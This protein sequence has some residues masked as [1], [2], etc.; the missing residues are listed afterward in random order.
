[1][2]KENKKIGTTMSF[3]VI[4]VALSI[5]INFTL[6]PYITNSVG[7]E[8]YGFVSLAK[9]F[10]SYANIFMVAL[11]SYAARYLSIAYINKKEK[12]FERSFYYWLDM[13]SQTR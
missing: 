10:T 1:M 6:T 8:A 12:D 9:S 5:G 3:G 11:N 4:P 2:G 13:C 7:T